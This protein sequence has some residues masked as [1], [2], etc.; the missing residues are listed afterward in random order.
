MVVYVNCVM[1]F[2][3]VRISKAIS[4]ICTRCV[5]PFSLNHPLALCPIDP[6]SSKVIDKI[7]FIAI[8]SHSFPDSF[9]KIT[10][11]A[12]VTI[13]LVFIGR[14]ER[15]KI[16]QEKKFHRS[17]WF[18]NLARTSDKSQRTLNDKRCLRNQFS[19]RVHSMI[20][21]AVINCRLFDY[22]PNDYAKNKP[23]ILPC[24]MTEH[25][26]S[27]ECRHSTILLECHLLSFSLWLHSFTRKCHFSINKPYVER[28]KA[29]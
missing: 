4:F 25:F 14:K 1:Q 11:W 2:H 12:R 29:F 10:L 8:A 3:R 16:I 19:I 22:W 15:R 24:A 23:K 20:H 17:A 5:W 9:F 26:R 18:N 21:V 27:R 7:G 28:I 13:K 6:D